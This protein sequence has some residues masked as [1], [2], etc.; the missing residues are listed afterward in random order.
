MLRWVISRTSGAS[1]PGKKSLIG[2]GD[3]ALNCFV[4]GLSAILKYYQTLDLFS[5]N[6]SIFSFRFEDHFRVNARIIPRLVLR[7]IGNSDFT[8]IGAAHKDSACVY[9]PE[10]VCRQIKERGFGT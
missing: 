3:E 2:L 6:L 8:F 7:D 4:K 5:F 1:F 9:L 10:S